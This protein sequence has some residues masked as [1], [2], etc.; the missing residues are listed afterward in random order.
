MI[1]AI[2]ALPLACEKKA[3]PNTGDKSGT[4][5]GTWVLDTKTVDIS[6]TTGSKTDSSHDAT[7]FT[8]EHFL[9]RLTDFFMA[10]AQKGTLLTFDIDDVDGSPFTYN[11]GLNQISFTKTLALSSGFLP[12]KIMSL[13][14]TY[15]VIKLTDKELVLSKTD[16]MNINTLSTKTVTA[17]SF[18]KLVENPK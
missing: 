10:F 7:D 17:Y 3:V 9:L 4:L 12:M 18:H 15:D 8:D 11:A 16:T 2:A 6:T 14:G 13:S 1:A 5:Y